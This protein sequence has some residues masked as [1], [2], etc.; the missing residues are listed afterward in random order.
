MKFGVA[1]DHRGLDLKNVVIDYLSNK[2]IPVEDY[3]TYSTEPADY[4][5]YGAK[6]AK[7]I[8]NKEI[9][10]GILICGTGIGISIAANRFK[11]VRCARI[12]NY[13]DAKLARQHNDANCLAFGC[14]TASYKVKDMLDAFI[15]TEF[16]GEERHV[17]RIK[18]LDE[19]D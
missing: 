17:R 2:G 11:G 14:K 18:M 12:N 5:K 19:L 1:C 6:V 10:F 8:V 15:N 9:D 4:P 13:D 16:T 7:A 3:G